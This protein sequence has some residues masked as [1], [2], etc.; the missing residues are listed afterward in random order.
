MLVTRWDGEGVA[1]PAASAT[2]TW[3]CGSFRL[4]DP[5]GEFQLATVCGSFAV[6]ADRPHSR[7]LSWNAILQQRSIEGPLFEVD[8]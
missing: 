3:P 8:S 7:G 6:C 4:G 5:P 1:R 2:V